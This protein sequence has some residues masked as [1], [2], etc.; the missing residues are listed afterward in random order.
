MATPEFYTGRIGRLLGAG[1]FGA[2]NAFPIVNNFLVWLLAGPVLYAGFALALRF[3]RVG[4]R[5]VVVDLLDLRPL[6]RFTRFGLRI[7]FVVVAV[8]RF[9]D[10]VLD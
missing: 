3:G 10:A 7:A 5:Q 2:M 9:V 6:A 1:P 4:E 8:E